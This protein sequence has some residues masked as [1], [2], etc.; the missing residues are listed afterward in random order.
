MPWKARSAMEEKF[1]FIMEWM[2][3]QSTMTE[4]CR[5]FGIS[6]TLGYV[7]IKRYLQEGRSGLRDAQ[8]P[9]AGLEQDR[10]L[11]GEAHHAAAQEQAAVRT[12]E[13]SRAFRGR[14]RR[15]GTASGFHD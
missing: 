9:A 14:H 6:R 11:R 2:A 1:S 8:G 15:E 10:H 13:H 7:Y 4:L 3:N 12:A 5:S